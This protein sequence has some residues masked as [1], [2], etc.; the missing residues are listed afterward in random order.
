M[1]KVVSIVGP[2]LSLKSQLFDFLRGKRTDYLQ[3]P[4]NSLQRSQ[5]FRGHNGVDISLVTGSQGAKTQQFLLMRG[6]TQ[7]SHD[8]PFYK[9]F[10]TSKADLLILAFHCE[11]IL[12]PADVLEYV[13]ENGLQDHRKAVLL[14]NPV[15]TGLFDSEEDVA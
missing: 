12:E 13:E 6:G 4:E 15:N 1:E 11:K 7:L 5:H 14:L 10:L 3:Y 8:F 9:E 2:S